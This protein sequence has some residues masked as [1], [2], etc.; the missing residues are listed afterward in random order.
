M[1]QDI[2][3]YCQTCPE[4]Q[5]TAGKRFTPKARMMSL[6][7]IETPSSHIAMDIVGTSWRGNKYA[8]MIHDYAIRNHEA[9]ALK[10][11]D[12]EA[13]A[14]K[15]MELIS[16]VVIPEEIL[17]HQGSNFTSK[18]LAVTYG[19]LKIKEIRTTPYHP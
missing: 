12:T 3:K 6:P 9:Y 14:E 8:L 19:M 13:I 7:I 4:C 16:R 15:L 10:T 5:K 2:K 18:L 11:I 1:S 17:S